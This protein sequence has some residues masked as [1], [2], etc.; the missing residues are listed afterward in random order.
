MPAGVGNLAR[1]ELLIV[2]FSLLADSQNDNRLSIL[3]FAQCHVACRAKWD[4]DFTEKR[5]GIL[6]LATGERKFL[7]EGPRAIDNVQRPLRGF[8]VLLDQEGIQAF[9]IGFRLQ[10]EADAEAHPLRF[11]ASRIPRNES[12]TSSF[13]ACSPEDFADSRAAS[14]RAM[15]SFRSLRCSICR[16]S[17]S[18]TKRLSDSPSLNTLSASF[19]RSGVTRSGGMVA[20]FIG[21]L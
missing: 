15:N 6:S 5:I 9:E 18:S 1:P 21:A 20:D 13:D 16:R 2:V 19:R 11:E 7:K 3:D 8:E 14:P 17:E 4:D 12:M 10:S